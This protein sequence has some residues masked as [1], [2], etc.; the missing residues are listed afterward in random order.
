MNRQQLTQALSELGIQGGVVVVHADL[1][2]L[3]LTEEDAGWVAEA[4]V[5]AVGPTGTVLMPTFTLDKTIVADPGRTSI[6][7]HPDLPTSDPVA[8]AFRHF[9]GTLRSNH[10]THSFAAL[11]PH[12]RELLSTHRDNNPL[13]PVKKLNLLHGFVVLVGAKLDRVIAL[14]LAQEERGM[15]VR[16]KAVAL[17]INAAGYRERVVI[18]PFPQCTRGFAKLETALEREQVR[19]V[20]LGPARVRALKLR[21]LLHLACAALVRSPQGFLCEV[22]GCS[23]CAA[24]RNASMPPRV[25]V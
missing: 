25:S 11:G 12:A 14:H 5:E 10:P 1:E 21:Y 24:R 19:E 17:R 23:S 6:P 2:A 8:E 7:F 9:A 22:E 18:D 15:A 4:I 16:Q 13:G 20:A 3:G